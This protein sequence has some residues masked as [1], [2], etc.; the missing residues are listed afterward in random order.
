MRISAV[1]GSWAISSILRHSDYRIVREEMEAG[2]ADPTT[3]LLVNLTVGTRT[4]NAVPFVVVQTD[5]GRWL[6]Q[7]VDLERVM[8]GGV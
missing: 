3:R 2:R 5:D 8:Q 6:V 7:E 1:A 4:I